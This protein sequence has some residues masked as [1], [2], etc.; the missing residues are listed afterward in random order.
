MAKR[1]NHFRKLVKGSQEEKKEREQ[2]T[3]EVAEKP[4]KLNRRKSLGTKET[5]NEA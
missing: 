3:R 2:I 4:L 1:L 5:P